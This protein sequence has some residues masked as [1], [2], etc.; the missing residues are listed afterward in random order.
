L[1]TKLEKENCHLTNGVEMTPLFLSTRTTG[2]AGP[3]TVWPNADGWSWDETRSQTAGNVAC[4][5]GGL[6]VRAPTRVTPTHD[7]SSPLT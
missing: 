1:P 4:T 3:S 6:S 5:V 2:R 7:C